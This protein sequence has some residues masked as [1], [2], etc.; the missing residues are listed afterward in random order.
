MGQ[1]SIR[2]ALAA[3]DAFWRALGLHLG[4]AEAVFEALLGGEFHRLELGPAQ[5]RESFVARFSRAELDRAMEELLGNAARIELPAPLASFIELCS[6]A[7]APLDPCLVEPVFDVLDAHLTRDAGDPNRV[8]AWSAPTLLEAFPR[9]VAA[10]DSE[11]LLRLEDAL[12]WVFRTAGTPLPLEAVAERIRKRVDVSEAVLEE[13]LARAPF[14]RRNP[15]QYGL[16]A[17]DV[18][19]GADAIAS[20]LEA[21]AEALRTGERA[22]SAVSALGLVQEAVSQ[23]WSP[24]LVWSL[25]GSDPVFYLSPG[26]DVTLRRWQH[27]PRGSSD[28]SCPSV[29]AA[30]RA[31]FDELCQAPARAS[32]EL[33]RRLRD[34]VRRL[35]RAGELD[36][37]VSI[38]LARQL[39]DL[40]ERLLEH[41]ASLEPPALTLASASAT[42]LL[43]AIAPD[44]ESED[45]A[46]LDHGKLSEAR[47]ALAAVLGWLRLPWL[48]QEL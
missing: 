13:R 46:P 21:L 12:R 48:P 16:L 37:F 47:A 9:E 34:E 8:A 29:P 38:P 33:A 41:A 18:P 40:H 6:A 20:A 22:L 31:R 7:C 1:P 3:D 36:D 17:R 15:N 30:A 44:E 4:A 43:E 10:A 45:P 23:P 19:G 25:I 14:V 35:E 11:A 42:L 5:R 28:V 26:C 32:D 39:A 2:R 27:A 24:D